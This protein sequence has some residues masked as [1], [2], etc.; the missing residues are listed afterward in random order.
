MI[1]RGVRPHSI[2]P[3]RAR[4]Y[5][6]AALIIGSRRAAIKHWILYAQTEYGTSFFCASPM[7]AYII[8]YTSSREKERKRYTQRCCWNEKN[9]SVSEDKFSLIR[10]FF[11]HY[12]YY[13][14]DLIYYIACTIRNRRNTSIHVRARIRFF[15]VFF[16]LP[17]KTQ[18]GDGGGTWRRWRGRNGKRTRVIIIHVHALYTHARGTARTHTLLHCIIYYH[19]DRR[20]GNELL[21]YCRETDHYTRVRGE[22]DGL[23]CATS[24][25]RRRP[26][27]DD[28]GPRPRRRRMVTP[29]PVRRR[30]RRRSIRL[31][32]PLDPRTYNNDVCEGG[33]FLFYIRLRLI[34][35]ENAIAKT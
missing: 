14:Y 7:R 11:S 26:E 30:R 20:R 22:R 3:G 2:R 10:L 24:A 34:D 35:S 13:Y 17:L 23:F 27:D 19:S 5:P 8:M 9:I 25:R 1:T 16:F 29:P 21:I 4:H 6:A 18:G 32:F 33:G 15:V 31:F 28:D 12:Y